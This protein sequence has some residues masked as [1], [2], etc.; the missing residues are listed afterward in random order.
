[1]TQEELDALLADVEQQLQRDVQGLLDEVS[2]EFLG[3]VDSATELVAAAF[4]VSSIR[5]MWRRRVPGLMTR[6]RAIADRSAAVTA[7]D[8]GEPVPSGSELDAVLGPYQDETRPLVEAVGDHLA[9]AA[10]QT[11]AEGVNAGDDLDQ[12]KT[13][14]ADVFSTSGAQLGPVRAARIAATEANRAYNAGVQAA[15]GAIVGPDRPL[16]KQWVTRRDTRVRE[17]HKDVNGQIRLL[18][19]PFDVGGFEMRYPGDPTAPADL[20]VN[21]RCVMVATAPPRTDE[22]TASVEPELAA[23]GEGDFQSRM[24]EQLKRY[25]LTGPGA[26]KIRWGTPGA[27]DRCVRALRPDFPQDPEG[28]CANLYHDATGRWPGQRAEGETVHTGAMVALMPHAD[29]AARLA[30]GSE[31]A[32]AA[33][34]LHVTLFY[35]GEGADWPEDARAEVHRA[36]SAAADW[37][38]PVTARAFGAAHWN[39]AGESP[40]W[41][42]NIGDDNEAQGSK[43]ADAYTEVRYALEDR[44]GESPDMPPQ[45]TPWAPH[46]AAVYSPE[47]MAGDL[48]DRCGPVVFDRI[49]VAFAGEYADYPLAFEDQP[50]APD[51]P[52]APAQADAASVP[53]TAEWHTP[54]PT[55]L[56]FENRQT[57]D[58]RVFGSGALYWD[59]DGPWPL[60]ANENFDSHDDA[61]LAGS[62]EYMSMA[63][64]RLNASGVL[65]LNQDAGCEAAVLL[66]QEA[67]L[68]VSVDLDDVDIE[69]VDTSGGEGFTARLLRASV[70]PTPDGGF[71][72]AGDTA[73]LMLA[74]GNALMFESQ[75]VRFHVG[76]DRLVPAAAFEISAAAGDPDAVDGTVV[77]EMRSGQYLMRITRGRVRGAT[78]VTIPAY[79]EARI[80]LKD[81]AMLSAAARPMT[82]LSAAADASDYERVLRHVRRSKTPSGPARIAQFLRIPIVAVQRYLAQAAARGEVV[83]ITRGLYTDQSS[84]RRAD[85]VLQ[86]QPL[87][88]PVASLTASVTGAV[89][90][91][92]APRE[93]AWDGSAATDRVFAWADGDTEKNGRASAYRDVSA[94]PATK[95][96]YKLGYADVVDGELTIIPR[97]VFAAQGAMEG[98]RGGVDIPENERAAVS[99]RLAAVR[100]HVDEVTGSENMDDMQASAWA[101]MAELP[102]MPAAWFREPTPEELPHGGQGVH[103]EGGRIFGW[104]AQRDVPHAGYA[105]RIVINELGKIDTT[106]FLRRPAEL[107]DGT[108]IKVG[109]FTMNAGHHRD[110]AECETAACQ[111]DDTRTVAGIVTVGMR[112]GGMWFAG[113]AAPWMSEWDR[114]VFASCQP[115]YHLKQGAGGRWELRAVLS[116][117]VPGHSSPLMASAVVER[118]QLAL[119]AAATMAEIETVVAEEQQRQ[120]AELVPAVLLEGGI[121]YDRLADSLVAAMAR[122]DDRKAAEAAELEALL[123]EGRTMIG[124]TTDEGA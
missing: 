16:V 66:A 25:W 113:A 62:I 99:E 87:D 63:D 45:Y 95:R 100:A 43:L 23:D 41:V 77:D 112:D 60:M 93:T 97:G 104:V 40:V 98:S 82:E 94:D 120:E 10:R 96:A 107:D 74:S 75:H 53:T 54:E 33:D 49:R 7:D 26:L 65:Y 38:G 109:A 44:G 4:S 24:P 102:P 71:V 69:M 32:E 111:F 114:Q 6:L 89:D 30:L 29:D 1:V 19:D 13:R 78:L 67:P 88:G 83:R 51:A 90:L 76:A 72:L 21:C 73:P 20:T 70:L 47:N 3:D 22:R 59:G 68:G 80:V 81:P 101:A 119:T 86:D 79:A 57:G 124:D 39:P 117:P 18:D 37:L 56:A 15:A 2:A 121:D 8:L 85:H 106:H 122:A 35:L 36:V 5:D 31:F 52:D 14:M 91:P 115:S 55:G 34:Q 46:I 48:A 17:A 123:A 27:F 50:Y 64:D 103:Y 61:A 28:L 105:K 11:L 110:G 12:L 92:V 9:E 42:W 116:V 58:N 108:V 118:S 84:F